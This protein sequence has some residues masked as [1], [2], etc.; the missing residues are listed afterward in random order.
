[1][2]DA[3]EQKAKGGGVI[4]IFKKKQKET[5]DEP[6]KD[7]IDKRFEAALTVV[8][9]QNWDVPYEW[10]DTTD[11]LKLYF[12][13]VYLSR[14]SNFS[15][16]EMLGSYGKVPP[17]KY[18]PR[19]ALLRWCADLLRDDEPVSV[20][21]V[22]RP[23]SYNASVGGAPSSAHIDC[24]AIDLDFSSRKSHRRA[25]DKCR[26]LHNSDV[27]FGIGVGIGRRRI[28]V[29]LFSPTYFIKHRPR[30]WIYDSWAERE[31]IGEWRDWRG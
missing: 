11:N 15:A 17:K 1:M 28:H 23:E 13:A 19:L 16:K 29:D 26:R 9:L 2:V 24:C 18:W 22:Y 7:E 8:G 20:A 10:H 4:N 3:G 12:D 25:L 14:R 27:N 21:H 31:S 5:G 6:I 30:H